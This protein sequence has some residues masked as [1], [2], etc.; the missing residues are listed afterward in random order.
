LR[1][2]DLG[3]RLAAISTALGAAD[4]VVVLPPVTAAEVGAFETSLGIT[5]PAPYR[6]FILEVASGVEMYDEPQL[7]TLE[8]IEGLL[9]RWGGDPKRPFP[10]GD[11]DA[12]AFRRALASDAD[13]LARMTPL[14]K[15]HL[16]DGCI[17]I[18]ERGGDAFVLV[19]TGEQCGLVWQSGEYDTPESTR[20]YGGDSDAPVDYVAWLCAWAREGLGVVLPLLHDDA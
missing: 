19:V 18:A 9:R 10:Y 20:R 16:L 8:Q 3:E 14:H 12:D 7:Y 1:L 2:T 13:R 17:T 11:V 15:P 4:D 5:L 6:R